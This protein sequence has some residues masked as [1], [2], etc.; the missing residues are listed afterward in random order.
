MK[1]LFQITFLFLVLLIL[2]TG[3]VTPRAG[4]VEWWQGYYQSR[5]ITVTPT[6]FFSDVPQTM[7][8]YEDS[9]P[10]L[11]QVFWTKLT[12]KKLKTPR[13]VYDIYTLH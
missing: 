8:T 6:Q 12:G 7:V 2:M 3:C 10:S 13:I 5:V 1:T 4:T 9:T 11:W